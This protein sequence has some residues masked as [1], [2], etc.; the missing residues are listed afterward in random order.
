V[1]IAPVVRGP[2]V[3]TVEE[4]GKTRV[5]DRYVISAPVAGFTRRI[6]LDVGDVV[7]RG[8]PLVVMEPLR[9]DVL[10]PRRRAEAQARIAAAEAALQVA[11]QNARA[12]AA[13]ADLAETELARLKRLY[14]A[15][16]TSR[17]AL[18]QAEAEARRTRAHLRSAEFAVD[19]ARSELEAARTALR[20]SA[21][22]ATPAADEQVVI[23]SPVDGQVLKISHKSARVVGAG[24]SLIEVGNPDA[25]E[26]EVDVLSADAVRIRPGTRVLF[27]R[28]G[29]DV[30]LEGRVR[31]VE[32]A[33]FTEVSAL[34][35]EEQRVW[36]IADITSPP[37]LW[38]R[39]GDGY[40][41]EASFVLWEGER[42]LQ[43]PTSALFRYRDDRGNGWAVFVAQDKRARLRPVQVG[44]RSGLRAEIRSGLSQGE[45][46]ITHPGESV[47]D[48]VR[49]EV[50]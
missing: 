2:L 34:G 48:G 18:D 24:E 21:A 20:Y 46:V 36:V 37:E 23:R 33:G 25:L 31:V 5:I 40:R 44:H 50:R 16:G 30:P 43:V 49:L 27:D 17:E 39:L 28:W 41:M 45:A 26:V 1:E 32:P 42:V 6:E 38:K 13:E 7:A 19:V 35:V 4:E 15:R 11:E 22:E 10:D 14:Q 9:S 47:E 12:A 3:V 8:Q 29:G